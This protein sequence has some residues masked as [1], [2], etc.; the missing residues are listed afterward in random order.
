MKRERDDVLR[1]CLNIVSDGADVT[2]DGRLFQKLTPETGEVYRRHIRSRIVY[3]KS[4]ASSRKFLK[5]ETFAKNH[6]CQ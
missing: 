4:D 5:Q 1:R 3:K 6:G 2:C